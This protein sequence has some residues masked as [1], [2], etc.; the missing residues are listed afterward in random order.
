VRVA[1]IGAGY[2]GLVTG[3]CLAVG[4]H[5]VTVMERDAGRLA[6]LE[7]GGCP[8]YEPGL[9]ELLSE[10]VAEGRLVFRAAD[11]S[12]ADAEVIVIAVGTPPTEDGAADLEQVDDAIRSIGKSASPGVAIVM[13]STVPV[14]TG[15][16][17]A[18][19]IAA[20]DLTYASNP[21]FLR[22]GSAVED[23][24]STDRIVVGTESVGA[25]ERVHELYRGIGAPFLDCD[26]ASAEMVK[27][28]SN[29]FLATKISFVNE[30]AN[31][32]DSVGAD[33]DSVVAGLGLDHR[34]GPAFLNAGIGYGGSC[35]P[36]DT[37]ALSAIAS[38]NGYH[39]RLLR[40]VIEVNADQRGLA[41]TATR[42]HLAAVAGATVAVLGLTFK[43]NT[44]DTRESP[45]LDIVESLVQEGAHVHVHDPVGVAPVGLGA[46]QMADI[47]SAL[48]GADACIVA[49]EWPQYIAIDWTKAARRMHPSALVF[50]GRNCL[51]ADAVRAAGLTYRGVGRSGPKPTSL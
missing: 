16:A 47:A 19:A 49:V 3:A 12:V 11:V 6:L 14:G 44:D 2:V 22:E 26:I 45:A 32:C 31:V 1:V 35:F 20:H 21:E 5:H 15:A 27:Y 28:A 10:N 40:A 39:F 8:I 38:A 48:E 29:A 36:K 37:R 43:P 25:R 33:V 13:K 51:S 9:P 4:G 17:I 41:V 46:E 34:I 30:I 18:R 24:F 50:D 42:E 23:W 7:S